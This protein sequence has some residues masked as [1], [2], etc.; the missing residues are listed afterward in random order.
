MFR[1]SFT[2]K[3]VHNLEWYEFLTE[4]E[5]AGNAPDGLFPKLH[6]SPDPKPS[7]PQPH[8][9]TKA[10]PTESCWN[11]SHVGECDYG[12]NCKYEHIGKAGAQR[13][14]V[15]DDDGYSLK[16][17]Q[18][19]NGC[20]KPR[21]PFNHREPPK[22]RINRRAHFGP[23]NNYSDEEGT[24]DPRRAKVAAVVYGNHL[25]T[26]DP[27]RCLTYADALTNVRVF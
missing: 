19:A 21:C 24:P 25:D 22:S 7:R 8:V 2:T 11:W 26:I 14:T 9:H 1:L 10:K 6:A 13:S 18:N 15:C 23:R 16:E 20:T 27:A 12:P 4:L 5:R 17:S 3:Q